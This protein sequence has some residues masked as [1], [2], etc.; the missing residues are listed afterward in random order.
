M[1][2]KILL[3][4]KLSIIILFKRRSVDA[5]VVLPLVSFSLTHDI[6]ILE[7]LSP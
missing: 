5:D 3:K 1:K 7:K 4:I 6:Y 2:L